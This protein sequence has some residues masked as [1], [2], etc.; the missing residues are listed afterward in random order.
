MQ[1]FESF[2]DIFSENLTTMFKF[3][4]NKN[5]QSLFLNEHF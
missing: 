4:T 2:R 1:F 5:A 3:M